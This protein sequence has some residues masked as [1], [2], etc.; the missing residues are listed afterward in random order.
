MINEKQI[1]QVTELAIDA[2]KLI[3]KFY[4]IDREITIKPDGSPVTTADLAANKLIVN[5]I[6][7]IAPEWQVIS[8]EEPISNQNQNSDHFWLI[9]PLDGTRNFIAK[10]TNFAVSIGLICQDTPIFGVIYQPHYQKL[11]YNIGETAYRRFL[12]AKDEVI[13]SIFNPEDGV[14]VVTSRSGD[15]KLVQ[16]FLVKYKV[17]SHVIVSSA[18]KLCMLAEASA[19]IYPCFT[20]TMSWDTA[21][22]HAILKAAGGEIYHI[23]ES[24]V[25]SYDKDKLNNPYF[26]ATG[27]RC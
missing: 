16:D 20:K 7:N 11:Y 25:L 13:S 27:L 19:N 9:D 18:V 12:G 1:K 21:G 3:M 5:E 17:K 24:L 2:G 6:K 23:D 15:S 14:D 26:L 4:D 22:G 10:N 8:E